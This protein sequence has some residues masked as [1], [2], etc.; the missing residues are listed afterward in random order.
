MGLIPRM[1]ERLFQLIEEASSTLEFS[2]KASFLEIY[3]EKIHDLLDR[4][5]YQENE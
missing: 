3:N 2:I 1:M 4:K 5:E